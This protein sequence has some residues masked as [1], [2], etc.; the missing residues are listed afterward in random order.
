MRSPHDRKR[1]LI[2][3]IDR[4][5]VRYVLA[6]GFNNAATYAAYLV[7][8]PSMGYAIAYSLT[9]VA[10]IVLAYYLSARFV[11]R[12]PL[13]WQ[14]AIQ[15][16]LVYVVQYGLGITLTTALIE[17]AQVNASIAPALVIVIT[18]PFTFW[19]TRWIITRKQRSTR[20]PSLNP[21]TRVSTSVAGE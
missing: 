3:I 14:H 19:L 17:G 1:W 5:S 9:Y 10:A 20:W 21:E 4:E 12:R 18:V 2:R 7:L 8:L 6:G 11:F 13:Q 15:F 16:P